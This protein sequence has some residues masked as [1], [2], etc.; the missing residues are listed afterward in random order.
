MLCQP[1]GKGGR[2]SGAVG[3]RR[4]GNNPIV[5][6]PVAAREVYPTILGTAPRPGNVRFLA[7]AAIVRR[8]GRFGKAVA[9][10][11]GRRHP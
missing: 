3:L 7:K 10:A 4:S 6:L 11:V 2:G 8:F 5:F 1:L 9:V